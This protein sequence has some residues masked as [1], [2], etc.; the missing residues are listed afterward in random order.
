[1]TPQQMNQ[2]VKQAFSAL[3][4]SRTEKA[5]LEESIQ[6]ASMN[7]VQLA[8]FRS[9]AFQLAT[10]AVNANNG[11]E[12]IQWLDDVTKLLQRSAPETSQELA[13]A[14]FSPHPDCPRRIRALLAEARSSVDICVFTIT[15]DRL[16]SGVLEA[17][18]R[19]VKVRIITDNDKAADLGSD[20]DELLRAGVALRVDRS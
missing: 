2:L 14:W 6:T 15:D 8:A 10:G 12:V 13:E 3:P 17:F 20:A 9:K 11:A 16:T 5:A 18:S 4:L 7:E 19:G 1:M